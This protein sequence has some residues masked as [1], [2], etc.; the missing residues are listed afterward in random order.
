MVSVYDGTDA[1]MTLLAKARGGGGQVGAGVEGSPVAFR[2]MMKRSGRE[3]K[4]REVQV[5]ASAAIAMSAKAKE[6][7]EAEE[8]NEIKRLVL[9]VP[10]PPS[11]SPT[12]LLVFFVL[13]FLGLI[14]YPSNA[15]PTAFSYAQMLPA[16]CDRLRRCLSR[17]SCFSVCL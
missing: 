7:A 16:K 13:T 3:D 12:H 2:V 8:R 14:V 6:E 15:N 5:P 1:D 4:S 17:T 9:E 10:R 11:P